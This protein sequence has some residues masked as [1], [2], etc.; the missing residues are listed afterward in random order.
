MLAYFLAITIVIVSVNLYLTAFIRSKIHRRDD[1]LWSGLG[2]FY[3]LT[4]W[5]CAGRITGAVL[6]G[7]LAISFVAIAFIWENAKLRKAWRQDEKNTLEGFSILNF[8]L[9][10]LARL[11]SLGKKKKSET[12]VKTPQNVVK[13]TE[14]QEL[15]PESES[16]GSENIPKITP[17]IQEALEKV[18]E[19]DS[20]TKASPEVAQNLPAPEEINDFI[21]DLA[22][23][24]NTPPQETVNLSQ[25]IDNVP[26]VEDSQ[27]N[28]DEILASIAASPDNKSEEGKQSF[29]GKIKSTIGG[30][31][32][33]KSQPLTSDTKEDNKVKE[34]DSSDD[35]MN[36]DDDTIESV[37]T[38][39]VNNT[40][41]FDVDNS[42]INDN[43]D[44]HTT[45]NDSL[46]EESAIEEEEIVSIAD[47]VHE[48]TQTID[49][50]QNEFLN[51]EEDTTIQ[52]VAVEENFDQEI[53]QF[54]EIDEETGL[55]FEKEEETMG[56][57]ETTPEIPPSDT[58]NSLTDLTDLSENNSSNDENPE[59]VEEEEES[60]TIE[61][62]DNIL[63]GWEKE[64]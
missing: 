60:K 42:Q 23:E 28:E 59:L 57:E 48:L 22:E 41:D 51:S 20:T 62:I 63:N 58:I 14:K 43:F 34:E 54:D 27:V 55:S 12:T 50:Q 18:D 8:I 25:K 13:K 1:F 46:T 39:G 64:N 6:L 7:Q 45:Q 32:K 35:W 53:N 52:K 26:D 29:F 21:D 16:L 2:L 36:S 61:N 17:E 19:E 33:G 38:D 24:E 10:V 9:S 30:I 37:Q 3:G 40:N 49:A 15:S 4:L 56:K 44:E 31:F 11:G 47:D 5:V